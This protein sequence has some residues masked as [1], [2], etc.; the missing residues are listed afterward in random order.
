MKKTKVAL[1]DIDGTVYEDYTI[2]PLA[3]YQLRKKIINKSCLD[4]L[5]KDL[6]FY[7]T[8]RLDYET[9]VANLLIH[10]A[11][12]LKEV[13][14]KM[15]L[16]QA[17]R[18]FEGEGNK[19]FPFFKPV[20]ALLEK[21]YDIYF[22]TAGPRFVAQAS[23]ELYKITG[24]ISSELETKDGFFT[25]RVRISLAKREEKRVAIKKLLRGHDTK[26][27]FA[28]G[29]AEGDIEM[30]N[31][32]EFP[33]CINPTLGLREIAIRKNW[34]IIKPEGVEKIV[35]TLISNRS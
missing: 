19:F 4:E 14:Y 12:G 20:V 18:F 26:H 17:K 6:K 23:S 21:K 10:W 13:S 30:L 24:F 3:E 28:F 7:K 2:F 22:V 31:S 9:S 15:V 33:I 29:D 35:S 32:V 27:S 25:G 8:G 5:Y 11:K 34:Q 1:F 16:G